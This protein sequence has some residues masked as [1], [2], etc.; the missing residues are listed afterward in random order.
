MKSIKPGRGP[1]AMGVVGSVVAILFGII[2]MFAASSIGAPPFFILFGFI[3]I[4][5]AIIQGIF[6]YKNATSKNRM[7]LLD[8]TDGNEEPDPLNKYFN[9]SSN[10]EHLT[11]EEE[12]DLNFCPYCGNKVIDSAHKFCAKCGKEVRG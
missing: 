2:W 11:L 3:F 12:N 4:G 8:I 7:S 9:R 5:V 10:Y 1:S 6:H